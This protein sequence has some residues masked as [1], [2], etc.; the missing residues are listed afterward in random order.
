MSISALA[1]RTSVGK[2]T[3][4]PLLK[5]LEEKK[6]VT[7]RISEDDDRKKNIV[8]TAA[9]RKLSKHSRDITNEA[10][11]STGLTKSEAGELIKM[12]RKLTKLG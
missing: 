7:R 8:L 6:L 2:P 12:C 10:F 1:K 11:C 3:M 4:T 9:G 5:R